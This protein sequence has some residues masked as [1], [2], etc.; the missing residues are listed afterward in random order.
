VFFQYSLEFYSGINEGI[1]VVN[2]NSRSIRVILAGRIMPFH[3][4]E[5]VLEAFDFVR[6]DIVG[7]AMDQELVDFEGMLVSQLLH[8]FVLG[9]LR[10]NLPSPIWMGGP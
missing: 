1:E 7:V 8:G 3:L 5:E 6:S 4:G 10:E 9:V 2:G